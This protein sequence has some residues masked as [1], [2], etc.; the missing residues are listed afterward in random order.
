MWALFRIG[1]SPGGQ[2]THFRMQGPGFELAGPHLVF[3]RSTQTALYPGKVAIA[4]PSTL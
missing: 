3:V 2:G 4:A 1:V